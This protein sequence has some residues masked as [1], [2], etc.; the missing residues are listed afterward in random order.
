M[1][2]LLSISRTVASN[3]GRVSYRVRDSDAYS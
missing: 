3:F 2:M 1:R